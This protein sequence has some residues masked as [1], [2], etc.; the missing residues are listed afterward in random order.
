M[1]DEYLDKLYNK[2]VHMV[3]VPSDWHESIIVNCFKGEC[4]ALI[5]GNYCGL[6][7]LDQGMKMFERVLE[8]IIREEVD[9][10]EIQYGFIPGRGTTD[11][12][13]ILHQL[14]ERF[15]H[16]NKQLY[17]FFLYL[18]KAFDRAPR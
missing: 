12:I 9:I 1:A 4:H 11:A 2:I 5:C 3:E 18:E 6:K 15:L 7:L 10:A 17:F 14:Q 16:K 8:K 13:S